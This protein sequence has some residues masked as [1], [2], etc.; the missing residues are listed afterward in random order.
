[1]GDVNHDGHLDVVVG[2][3]EVAGS[4]PNTSSRIYAYDGVTHALLPG[5]P[6][7][8]PSLSASG[9]PAVATGVIS[10]PALF[11]KAGGGGALQAVTGAFLQ[12][13]P[14]HPAFTINPDGSQG[15]TLD[16]SG[17]SDA[18][19]TDLPILYAI[20]Q[21]AV[22]R[23][24]SAANPAIVTG[25]LGT[26]LTVDTAA[27]PG[28]KTT[29][30]HGVA[31]FDAATGNRVPTFPRQIEDW[32]FLAGPVI[33][34]V[35]GDGTRQVIEG[36]GAG[37]VH[38]FDPAG[39]ANARSN[40]STSLSRYSDRAEPSGFPISTGTHY[41]T[42]T[43]AVGQLT[44]GGAVTVAT[45]T[46]D[47][48]LF[49]TDTKGRPAANDQWWH[50]HHDER[51][52]GLYGVDARPPATLD[53]LR[54][55][56][57]AKRGTVAVSWREVGDDWWVGRPA[58]TE[59]RWSTSP[60]GDSDF[61]H[62][63]AVRTATPASSG[64][65]ERVAL[66]GLP[67]GRRVYL[68]ERG[69]DDVGNRA[70]IART[71]VVVPAPTCVDRTAPRVAFAGARGIAATRGGVRVRG[72]ASDRG[73]GPR[74][75]GTVRVVQVAVARLDG[76]SC[77]FLS[78]KGRAG[79]RR[80]CRSPIYRAAEFTAHWRFVQRGRLAPGRYLVLARAIDAVHRRSATASRTV[81]IR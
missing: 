36:S 17:G 78:S 69:V 35:K 76:R 32:Q 47:G 55:A 11:P 45:A 73:C 40:L 65:V 8:L 14:A 28:K 75:R 46:R 68:A 66:S 15:A 53:A 58:R 20:A 79:S 9:V 50:F 63:H 56:P 7:S 54:A 18:N 2:T 38:A 51:N 21:T 44:R 4:I 62:A 34:D 6:V 12:G 57:G 37:F 19:F 59:L 77:R 16:T 13:D 29:F 52:T 23:L 71:S 31:A 42:S 67:A 24:G 3:E 60:I 22:G 49:L 26:K 81:R 25:G 61:A 39:A 30:Q 10:S 74:G 48:Y 64:V 80:S 33:A 70:L 1:V 72:T 5:W 43:P 27:V 41:I